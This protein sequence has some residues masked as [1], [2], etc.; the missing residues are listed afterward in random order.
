MQEEKLLRFSQH[1]KSLNE[2]LSHRN[3]SKFLRKA[4]KHIGHVEFC[5]PNLILHPKTYLLISN[6]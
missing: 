1:L 3:N 6:S 5:L 4:K 2:P